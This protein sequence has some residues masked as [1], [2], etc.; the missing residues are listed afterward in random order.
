M[1]GLRG[2]QR[3]PLG[4]VAAHRW[5]PK[6]DKLV[7]LGSPHHGAP[8]ERGGN[9]IDLLLGVSRYSAPLARLGK[10]RSAGVT[11]MRFGIVLDEHWE[12]R[13]R[14]AHGG[15]PRRTLK[16]P[17]GVECYAIAATHGT[18]PPATSSP[19][20]AWSRSTARSAGTAGRS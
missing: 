8:L 2:A 12:G 15:D 5:R 7:C 9:W 11:D 14:F 4:E 10:I 17:D 19:A 18:R 13:D 16:L 6:L 20:T 1:G 3:L